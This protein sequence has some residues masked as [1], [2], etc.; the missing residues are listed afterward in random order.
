MTEELKSAE[1]KFYKKGY[2]LENQFCGFGYPTDSTQFELVD[3]RGSV[4]ID[5]L[6][7]SQVIALA[8]ML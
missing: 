2:I 5:H 8:E 6:S 7:E 3:M 4:A 1:K